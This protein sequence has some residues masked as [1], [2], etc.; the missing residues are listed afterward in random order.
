M[1]GKAP[2]LNKLCNNPDGGNENAVQRYH[3]G[4]IVVYF[5]P[6]DERR[7]TGFRRRTAYR[8]HESVD[9]ETP[10]VAGNRHPL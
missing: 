9:P 3:T 8:I 4:V 7:N 1:T 2:S 5:H 10:A 6:G